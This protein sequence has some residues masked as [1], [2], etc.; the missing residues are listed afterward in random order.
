LR[1]SNAAPSVEV[2]LEDAE[3]LDKAEAEAAIQRTKVNETAALLRKKRKQK[4]EL[5]KAADSIS[6]SPLKKMSYTPKTRN[7]SAL[8]ERRIFKE[9]ED[10]K[11]PEKLVQEF[12]DQ[13]NQEKFVQEFH[14]KNQEKLVQEFE[15]QEKQNNL[16][17]RHLDE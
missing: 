13:T 3:D 1:A 11:N 14:Q 17:R 4:T 9:F 5:A 15:D 6:L 7:G 12:E 10:Q 2:N 8:H 16:V